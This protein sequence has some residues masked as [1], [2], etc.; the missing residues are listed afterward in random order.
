MERGVDD[1]VEMVRN[2]LFFPLAASVRLFGWTDHVGQEGQ[3]GGGDV[4]RDTV[5]AKLLRLVRLMA[6]CLTDP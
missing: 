4:A 3:M 2:A 5:P 1:K 6:N